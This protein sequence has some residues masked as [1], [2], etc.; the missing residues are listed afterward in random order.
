MK[1]CR[2]Q[3]VDRKDYHR[4]SRF[5]AQGHP[6]RRS[7]ALQYKINGVFAFLPESIHCSW[8]NF[9]PVCGLLYITNVDFFRTFA[10]QEYYKQRIILVIE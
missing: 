10:L 5:S 4:Y 7:E 1:N 2:L 8:D 9:I 6:H 3:H